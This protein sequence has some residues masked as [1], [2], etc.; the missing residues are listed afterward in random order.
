MIGGVASSLGSAIGGLG[1]SPAGVQSPVSQ[2]P[3]T[4]GFGT[5]LGAPSGGFQTPGVQLGQGIL[6]NYGGVRL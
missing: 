4:T 3:M 5:V 6:G 1:G 2:T